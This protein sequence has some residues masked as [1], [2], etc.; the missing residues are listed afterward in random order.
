MAIDRHQARAHEA[1]RRAVL[2]TDPCLRTELELLAREWAALA[3]E[4]EWLERSYGPIASAQA[5]SLRSEPV[6][7]QQQQVQPKTDDDRRDQTTHSMKRR[8]HRPLLP[9]GRAIARRR[10]A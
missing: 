3:E 9:A 1:R 7:Q 4:L 2:P 8:P 5:A 6:L 10:R